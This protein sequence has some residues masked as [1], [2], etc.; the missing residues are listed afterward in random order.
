MAEASRDDYCSR[1]KV[2]VFSTAEVRDSVLPFPSEGTIAVLAKG[3]TWNV[4]VGGSW[5]A[6]PPIHGV[7]RGWRPGV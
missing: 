5:L 3:N 4:Y 1:Q 7:P 6:L 2:M